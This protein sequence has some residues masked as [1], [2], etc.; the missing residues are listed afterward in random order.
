M[1]KVLKGWPLDRLLTA[2][3]IGSRFQEGLPVGYWDGEICSSE[4]AHHGEG[5]SDDSALAVE[6]RTTRATDGRLGIVNDFVGQD[7]ADVTLRDNRAYQV[8]PC[9]FFHHGFRLVF[10][11]SRN[12]LDCFFAAASKNCI[13]PRGISQEHDRPTANGRTIIFGKSDLFDFRS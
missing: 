10:G 13:D 1:L 11:C 12:G 9:K 6:K 4:I 5:N 8:P 3:T 2:K 7:I